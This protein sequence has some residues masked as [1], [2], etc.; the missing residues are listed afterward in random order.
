MSQ[1]NRSPSPHFGTTVDDVPVA[2]SVWQPEQE[3]PASRT[4]ETHTVTLVTVAVAVWQWP[5]RMH[6][7]ALT[8]DP[9]RSFFG[10]LS[11]RPKTIHPQRLQSHHYYRLIRCRICTV[12]HCKSHAATGVV[13]CVRVMRAHPIAARTGTAACARHDHLPAL[14]HG[15]SPA[16][17]NDNIPPLADIKLTLVG[18]ICFDGLPPPPSLTPPPPSRGIPNGTFM[19]VCDE[20]KNA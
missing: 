14:T 11:Q 9:Q 2:K 3:A 17:A 1:Q 6:L 15:R 8:A 4:H 19:L 18:M 20:L 16:S 13:T 5:R 12:T 7:V 10:R